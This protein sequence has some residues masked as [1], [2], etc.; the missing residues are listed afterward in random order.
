MSDDAH[1]QRIAALEAQIAAQAAEL[2]A[3]KAPQA[4]LPPHQ[5]V[6]ASQESSVSDVQQL[7]GSSNMVLKQITVAEGG[8]LIVGDPPA[9]P[10]DAAAI[11]E[12]LAIYLNTLLNH[13]RLLSFQG[14][15]TSA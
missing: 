12:A 2:A 6:S 4:A 15:S 13:Y 9:L 5:G 1:T 8:T 3:L 10:P 14:L 11:Q 7:H